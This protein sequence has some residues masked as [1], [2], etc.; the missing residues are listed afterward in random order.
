MPRALLQVSQSINDNQ[1]W[2]GFRVPA[3][4]RFVNEE[5]AYLSVTSGG[6]RMYINMEDYV[7]RQ[8]GSENAPFLVRALFRNP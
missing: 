7:S 2:Q 1:L 5:S 8:T 4:I 6:P 3:L